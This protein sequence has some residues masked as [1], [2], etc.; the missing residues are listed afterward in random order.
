MLLSAIA[1]RLVARN[2]SGC[3]LVL[4]QHMPVPQPQ[5]D[6]IAAVILFG[7]FQC[8][9]I[10]ILFYF[11]GIFKGNSTILW[12]VALL[13]A[14]QL[15]S[16]LIRSGY[17]VSALF[18][19]NATT[20]LVFFIGPL[21][22]GFTR[23]RSGHKLSA[24]VL[25]LHALPGVLYFLYSFN[26]YLQPAAYKYNAVV[27]SFYPQMQTVPFA[28]AFSSDPWRL[29]GLVVVELLCLHMAV[30]AILSLVTVWRNRGRENALAGLRWVAYINVVL[31][32]SALVLFFSQGGVINGFVFFKSPFPHFAPDMCTT[33]FMYSLSFYLLLK[34]EHFRQHTKKYSKSSLPAEFRRH[35]LQTI[36]ALTEAHRLYADPAFSLE[37]LSLQSGIAKHHISQILNEELHVNFYEFT[38]RYRIEEAKRIL[39]GSMDIKMEQLAYRLGYKS[40]VTFFTAFKKSTELT[41][42]QYKVRFN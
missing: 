11:K 8:A 40:K 20:P 36:R 17:I 31:L 1:S 7:M 37:M 39:E 16:F 28:G 33:L 27:R 21:L 38:H 22:Y 34:P 3:L 24:R 19:V 18:L 13:L 4:T 14:V 2:L 15:E 6:A 9:S 30:Y 32:A 25:V 12:L 35:K 42:V 41:P 29:Q 23:S 10:L 26:F 5:I